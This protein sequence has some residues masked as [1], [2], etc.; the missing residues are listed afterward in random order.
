MYIHYGLG[1]I[2]K[3]IAQ[4]LKSYPDAYPVYDREGKE[5]IVFHANNIKYTLVKYNIKEK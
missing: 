1:K 4:I 5:S 3:N 2:F